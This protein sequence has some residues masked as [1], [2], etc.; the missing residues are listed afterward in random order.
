M[1]PT[2][3]YLQKIDDERNNESKRVELALKNR[4]CPECGGLLKVRIKDCMIAL[5][6]YYKGISCEHEF[7]RKL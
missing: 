5:F 2:L 6:Y 3:E 1:K 4:I 7:T